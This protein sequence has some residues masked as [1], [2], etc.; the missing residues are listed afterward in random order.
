[1]HL[2]K[3]RWLN[4]NIIKNFPRIWGTLNLLEIQSCLK[5]VSFTFSLFS[6]NICVPAKANFSIRTIH[7]NH[8]A[9][10]TCNM[11]IIFLFFHPLEYNLV[12]KKSIGET[13]N[14]RYNNSSSK[15]HLV[16][17]IECPYNDFSEKWNISS[18]RVFI[19]CA[20]VFFHLTNIVPPPQQHNNVI[21][22]HSYLP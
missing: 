10:L 19:L 13:N 18:L 3:I 20:Y 17:E 16:L 22:R 2:I 14:S 15:R 9:K 12:S 4:R 7:I 21:T 5:G 11:K 6:W 1:M 8:S